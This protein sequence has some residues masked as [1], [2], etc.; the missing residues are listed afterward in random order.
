MWSLEDTQ[1]REQRAR[2]DQATKEL[3]K[4]ARDLRPGQCF[5][6]AEKLLAIAQ[7]L[8]DGQR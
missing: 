1:S 8:E 2:I 6:T 3:R 4:L 7:R 5:Y